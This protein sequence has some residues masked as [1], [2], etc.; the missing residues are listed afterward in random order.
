MDTYKYIC[1][2]PIVQLSLFFVLR[3]RELNQLK[4]EQINIGLFLVRDIENIYI[5]SL[6]YHKKLSSFI[7]CMFVGWL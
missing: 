4:S 3:F 5:S 2:E 6:N 1:C 7:H